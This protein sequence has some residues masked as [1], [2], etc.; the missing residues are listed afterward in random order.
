MQKKKIER[1][2]CKCQHMKNKYELV[3]VNEQREIE[4]ELQETMPNWMQ[5]RGRS[6]ILSTLSQQWNK[7]H[8]DPRLERLLKTN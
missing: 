8:N 3:S 7:T 1:S 2:Q 5:S 6:P 4:N